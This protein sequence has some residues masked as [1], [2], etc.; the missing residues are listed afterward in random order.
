MH[1]IYSSGQ[2]LILPVLVGISILLLGN[3]L[4]GRIV[5]TRSRP[6]ALQQPALTSSVPSRPPVP[7]QTIVEQNTSVA[8]GVLASFDGQSFTVKDTIAFTYSPFAAAIPPTLSAD[9]TAI[10]LI[11]DNK[12]IKR[13]LATREETVIYRN[14]ADALIGNLARIDDHT[15]FFSKKLLTDTGKNPSAYLYTLAIDTVIPT[16]INSFK[17]IIY[18]GA[19]YLFRYQGTYIVGSFGGDACAGFGEI[20]SV[21]TENVTRIVETGGGCNTNPRLIGYQPET[22][23]LILASIL[24]FPEFAAGVPEPSYDKPHYDVLYTQQ[25]ETKTI[26]PIY[27]LKKISDQIF[28]L[29]Y[30]PEKQEVVVVTDKTLLHVGIEEKQI[31]NRTPISFS[32]EK[33]YFTSFPTSLPGYS[34]GMN[35]ADQTRQIQIISLSS[36]TTTASVFPAEAEPNALPTYLGKYNNHALFFF[37]LPY[38]PS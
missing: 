35:Y 3:M 4:S 31:T 14:K 8:R 17:P 11:R 20:W 38:Q 26:T 36:G 37:F 25:V 19:T 32:P 23:N 7:T 30:N 18:G 13:L 5:T 1:S 2:K 24:P 15:L 12:I 6:I 33:I 16:K 27:D 21:S 34:M 22:G 10:Y 29:L 28:S 9:S